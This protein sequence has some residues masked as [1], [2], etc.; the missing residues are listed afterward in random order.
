MSDPVIVPN[1]PPADMQIIGVE[2]AVAYISW[3]RA[4]IGP[5]VEDAKSQLRSR[6]GDEVEV[7]TQAYT[8]SE[9][10]THT[11]N[12]VGPYFIIGKVTASTGGERPAQIDVVILPSGQIDLVDRWMP[13]T[14]EILEG[15]L[16]SVS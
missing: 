11:Y 13:L 16:D 14:R 12:H 5:V 2:H 4:Y 9:L 3:L 7:G 6:Y 15:E 8:V 1:W 10:A